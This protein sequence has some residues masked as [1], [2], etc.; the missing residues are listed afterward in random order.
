VPPVY[1]LRGVGIFTFG[2]N[3]LLTCMEWLL[4]CV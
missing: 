2:M 4:D 3:V 1:C